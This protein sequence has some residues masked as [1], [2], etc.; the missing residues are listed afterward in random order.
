M[1]LLRSLLE[2]ATE[3]EDDLA[4][5]E[6]VEETRQDVLSYAYRELD[7][8]VKAFVELV[9]QESGEDNE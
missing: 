1:V 3:A 4:I 7:D 2:D 6:V 8:Q 9:S 5:K